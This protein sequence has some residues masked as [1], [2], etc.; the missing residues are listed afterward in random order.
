MI[1]K[2]INIFLLI[3]CVSCNVHKKKAEATLAD[4]EKNYII[5]FE[6]KHYPK[7]KVSNANIYFEETDAAQLRKVIAKNKYT[8]IIIWSYDCAHCA[9]SLYKYVNGGNQLKSKE[10]SLVLLSSKYHYPDSQDLL[11]N[12]GYTGTAFLINQKKYVDDDTATHIHKFKQELCPENKKIIPGTP[13][14]FLFNQNGDLLFL[15]LSERVN[16][17][18]IAKYIR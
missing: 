12:S 4:I 13:A 15:R 3:L 16:A 17:D 6:I 2:R 11:R 14:H 8:W 7:Q 9:R 5:P 10:V 1:G 18:T